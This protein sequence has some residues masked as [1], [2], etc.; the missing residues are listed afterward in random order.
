M[1]SEQRITLRQHLI[2]LAGGVLVTALLAWGFYLA[3]TAWLIPAP[4]QHPAFYR[5]PVTV[6]AVT[7]ALHPQVKQVL[8]NAG[9]SYHN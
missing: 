2:I 1:T 9:K 6:A 7:G 3:M 4:P 8:E 5:P